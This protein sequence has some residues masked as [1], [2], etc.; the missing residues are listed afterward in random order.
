MVIQH[1]VELN[2]YNTYIPAQEM[3][4]RAKD[5]ICYNRYIR[6][7]IYRY[8]QFNWHNLHNKDLVLITECVETVALT[9]VAA[10]PNL[11]C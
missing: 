5:A 2:V 3:V 4:V 11:A 1:N 10:I 8:I 6:H 7:R 9:H